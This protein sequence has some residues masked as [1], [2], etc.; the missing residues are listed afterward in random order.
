[1]EVFYAGSWRPPKHQNTIRFPEYEIRNTDQGVHFIP[2][3]CGEIHDEENLEFEDS[4]YR[5][6]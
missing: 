5:N 1:M 3:G 2:Y 4:E 6:K